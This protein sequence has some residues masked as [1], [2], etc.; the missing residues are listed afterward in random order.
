MTLEEITVV[1][2]VV[3][4]VRITVQA[5]ERLAKD[6][7]AVLLVMVHT[8]LTFITQAVVVVQVLLEE[9]LTD[10]LLEN[11]EMVVQD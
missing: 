10:S 5:L 4:V 8:M 11:Q 3:L 6:M 2:A 7:L 1:L 9:M